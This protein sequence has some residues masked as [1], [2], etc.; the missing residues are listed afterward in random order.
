MPFE[1]MPN[2]RVLPTLITPTGPW[3]V[4]R[5]QS[6]TAW[7]LRLRSSGFR[8]WRT[9]R[10]MDNDSGLHCGGL[11]GP[12]TPV[13]LNINHRNARVCPDC[14]NLPAVYCLRLFPPLTFFDCTIVLKSLRVISPWSPTVRWNTF[15]SHLR[16][17]PASSFLSLKTRGCY[18][19]R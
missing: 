3:S 17:S 4:V 6:D 9:T 7:Q 16:F 10:K 1:I 19:F 5:L 14:I 2:L 8:L 18:Y 15:S 13:L 11:I 12:P